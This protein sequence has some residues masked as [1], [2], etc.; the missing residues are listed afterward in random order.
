MLKIFAYSKCSL[1]FLYGLILLAIPA[2]PVLF[3]DVGEFRTFCDDQVFAFIATNIYPPTY[4]IW[5]YRLSK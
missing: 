5:L 1:L 2:E 3:G 4:I